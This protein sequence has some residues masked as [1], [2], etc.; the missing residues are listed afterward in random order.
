MAFPIVPGGISVAKLFTI[1][2]VTLLLGSTAFAVGGDFER[3][4]ENQE[5][6]STEKMMANISPAGAH[7]GVVVASPQKAFPDYWYH[8][9]RDAALTMDTVVS[10]WETSI[11]KAQMTYKQ[12]LVEFVRFSRKN[13]LTNA[14]GGMGEPKFYVDGRPYDLDWCRPQN[15]G[16]ALRALTLARF[17]NLLLDRGDRDFVVNELYDSKIPTHTVVKADLEFVSHH[18]RAP[19]CDIWEEVSG[20]HFYTRLA[21]KQALVMGSKLA[22]RLGD[23]GASHWY[24]SQANA[25]EATLSQFWNA[26]KAIYVPHINRNGGIDYKHSG[27][28]SQV[29][30]AF[31]HAPGTFRF[32]DSRVL[33]TL[34]AQTESFRDIY[35]INKRQGVAGFGIGR[36]PED[37]YDGANMQ[38]GNPWIL[39]TVAFATVHYKAAVEVA[40]VGD[41]NLARG[42]VDAGDQYLKR[43]QY[44]ANPDGSLSEQFDRNTG[45]MTSARDLTWSH[46]ELIQASWA[47]KKALGVVRAEAK[48]LRN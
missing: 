4:L 23:L 36:Y 30:L 20:D 34:R 18:W 10:L 42:F 28:D 48:V 21:M 32:S 3:W 45:F 44:H 31:L 8:W 43:I 41:M 40:Q 12:R 24:M 9:T 1:L 39:I 16:P 17:A 47:R 46:A 29:I 6:I 11:R 7:P 22:S 19:N 35:A 15:D 33:G 27:L 13:Q 25:I 14:K 37:R 2:S 5:K 38:G 26:Q